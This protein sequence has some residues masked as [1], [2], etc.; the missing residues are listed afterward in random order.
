MRVLALAYKK[1]SNKENP[2]EQSRQ[3]VESN[4]QFG[5]FIAF[6]CKIRAD[7]SIVIQSLNESDHKVSMLTGDA[8]L[9]SLHV[10]KSVGI[11]QN[12]KPNVIL[13]KQNNSFYWNFI[14]ATQKNKQE[15]Q[16]FQINDIKS[17]AIKYNLL[18]TEEIFLQIINETGNKTSPMW[19]NACYFKVF[20]RMSPQGK[21]NIIRAIQETDNDYHVLMCG[22]G[23]NDVGALK[24]VCH[25]EICI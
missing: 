18:I 22:D 3:W 19:K 15:N 21:A 16:L 7:S 1:V 5:G 11:C 14:D 12:D 6:E 2:M 4:L 24:Q 25:V 10:A 23:G 8:L 13:I 20:A 9:T 17:Y